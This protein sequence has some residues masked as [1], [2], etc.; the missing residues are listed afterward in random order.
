MTFPFLP[1]LLSSEDFK[2]KDRSSCI[3]RNL[4][5]DGFSH[6]RDGSDEVD[7]PT[8]APPA[9]PTK[10]LRCRIGSKPCSDGTECV[11]FSHV[12]DGEKDCKDGS[13]ELGCGGFP[14]MHF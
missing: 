3:G 13:D 1:S 9:A 5:C 10:V 11:L 8:V 2:C 12:C 14:L 4:I 6:C 7:C